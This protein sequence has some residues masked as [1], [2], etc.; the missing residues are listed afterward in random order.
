MEQLKALTLRNVAKQY[1]NK[2]AVD[3][4]SLD[5]MRGSVLGV[6]GKNGCGKSTLLKMIAGIIKP[7]RGN[8]DVFGSVLAITEAGAGFHP[9]LTG[10]E[11]VDMTA[12]LYGMKRVQIEQILPDVEEFSELKGFMDVPVKTYSQG[13]FLRLAFG[14]MIHLP[15]DILLLD[16][17]LAVGDEAFRSK[18]FEKL[19]Q[20]KQKGLTIIIVSHSFDEVAAFCDE[21]IVLNEGKIIAKGNP[22]SVFDSYYDSLFE[23]DNDIHLDQ[24]NDNCFNYEKSGFIKILSV[25]IENA[26]NPENPIVFSHPIRVML[27]WEKLHEQGSVFFDFIL[28]D[29]LN[30]PVLA[31]ANYYGLNLEHHLAMNH[32]QNGTFETSCIIPA[33][34]MNCDRFKL[35]VMAT[36]YESFVNHYTILSS[37][38]PLNL[39]IY[40]EDIIANTLFWQPTPAPIRTTMH[41]KENFAPN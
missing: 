26:T 1:N 17:V 18:C 24:S 12:R 13:M 8:I 38:K 21:C 33:N 41:W 15:L 34:F 22:E 20:L 35:V 9:D 28:H 30:R 36:Y 5:V 19:K 3:S 2:I 10:R 4:V 11:N 37:K 32:N 31:T 29:K 25:T 39:R 16:E 27:K 23:L 7:S 14:L 40:N 6:V